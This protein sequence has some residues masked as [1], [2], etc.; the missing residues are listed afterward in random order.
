MHKR[1]AYLFVCAVALALLACV[2]PHQQVQA[3]ADQSELIARLGPPRETYNLPNGGKRLMWPTQPMGSTTTAADIDA[4]G[5]V[6]S[7]RQVLQENEFHRA[8]VG[9]WTRDDVLINFGRPF[10]DSVFLANATGSLVIPV[11]GEQ[12]QPPAFPLLLRRSGHPATNTEI[13]RPFAGPKP[14]RHVLGTATRCPR[15]DTPPREAQVRAF[16]LV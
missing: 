12:H 3:G 4:S 15:P 5:K 16:A 10:E 2:Q 6:L 7:V 8:E 1:F 11:C 14:P 13:A 9:K